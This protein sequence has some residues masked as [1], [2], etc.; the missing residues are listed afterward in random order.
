MRLRLAALAGLAAALACASCANKPASI[1]ISPKKVKIYGLER[2]NGVPVLEMV[3]GPTLAERLRRGPLPVREVS[4]PP[5]SRERRNHRSG[6]LRLGEVMV[7][8]R[9]LLVERS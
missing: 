5:L 1:D 4:P 9:P 6:W 8:A 7:D 2:S 3:E